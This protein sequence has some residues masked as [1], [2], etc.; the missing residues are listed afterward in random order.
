M[1]RRSFVKSTT[2]ASAMLWGRASFA[3]ASPMHTNWVVRGSE[4]FD[5]LS[6]LSPLSGNP[7]YLYY[8]QEAVAAFAPHMPDE[9]MT[10]LKAI[11]QRAQDATVLLS[12]FIDVRFSAEPDF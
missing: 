1:N 6:F 8:Y 5:A 12:H 3:A 7:F 9:S 10:M 2:A 4:G 11:L